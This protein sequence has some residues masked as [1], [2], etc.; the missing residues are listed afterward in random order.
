MEQANSMMF[1]ENAKAMMPAAVKSHWLA[2]DGFYAWLNFRSLLKISNIAGSV[3][4][5]S[6]I[7][8]ENGSANGHESNNWRYYLI[9]ADK[10]PGGE[11]NIENQI[12]HDRFGNNKQT[13]DFDHFSFIANL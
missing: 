10:I 8:K 7:Q 6:L 12:I 5:K 11:P 3:V 4:F 2:G 9:K 13:G 1:T